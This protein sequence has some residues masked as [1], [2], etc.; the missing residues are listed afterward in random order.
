MGLNFGPVSA[1]A[2]KPYA[3]TKMSQYKLVKIIVKVNTATMPATHRAATSFTGCGNKKTF[4]DFFAKP[5]QNHCQ[6][7]D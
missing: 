2:K 4:D 6:L 7:L 1:R 3:S 5:P